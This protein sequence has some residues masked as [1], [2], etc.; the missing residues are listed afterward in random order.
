MTKIVYYF[1]YLISLLP[2]RVI[3][4]LADIEYFFVYHL[5]GYRKKIVRHNMATA[6]PE[7]TPEE[8]SAIERKFYRRFQK[9]LRRS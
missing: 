9:R 6:F 5:V 1:F 8:L 3:Y 2:W 7:K 4:V